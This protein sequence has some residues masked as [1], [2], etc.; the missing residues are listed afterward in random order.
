MT[1][2]LLGHLLQRRV[3]EQYVRLENDTELTLYAGEQVHQDE[4]VAAQ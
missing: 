1:Y 4:G 3:I 2:D